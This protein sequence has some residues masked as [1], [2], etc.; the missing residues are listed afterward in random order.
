MSNFNYCKNNIETCPKV[1]QLELLNQFA[2]EKST[3]LVMNLNKHE[4]YHTS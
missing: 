4:V 3:L 2:F 1:G